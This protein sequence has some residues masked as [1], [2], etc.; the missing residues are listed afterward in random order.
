MKLSNVYTLY[1][2]SSTG[3]VITLKQ[4]VKTH[5]STHYNTEKNTFEEISINDKMGLYIDFSS[6]NRNNTVFIWDNG[7]YII[8]ISADLDKNST[9]DLLN[10]AKL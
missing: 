5:F 3:Q 6:D 9:L 8:E 4:L 2:N 10:I 1:M 7:D